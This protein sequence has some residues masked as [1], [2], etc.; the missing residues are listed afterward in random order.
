MSFSQ[1]FC[2]CVFG[3]TWSHG[4]NAMSARSQGL[5]H[6]MNDVF[7][8]LCEVHMRT[9]FFC[10]LHSLFVFFVHFCNVSAQCT[11]WGCITRNTSQK[12][13]F[14]FFYFFHTC[15]PWAHLL[16]SDNS[17]LKFIQIMM[18]FVICASPGVELRQFIPSCRQLWR[19]MMTSHTRNGFSCMFLPHAVRFWQ[20]LC[21]AA[22]AWK[23]SAMK[24]WGWAPHFHQNR[25]HVH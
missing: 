10:S 17:P 5:T 21:T 2:S 14:L 25:P 16:T 1:A 6:H 23:A 8:F 20:A 24:K 12:I 9:L 15:G 11:S 19:Q 7:G 13:F 3:L 22:T 18:S 4:S